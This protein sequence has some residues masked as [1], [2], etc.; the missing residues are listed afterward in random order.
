MHRALPVVLDIFQGGAPVRLLVV[1]LDAFRYNRIN[2]SKWYVE[3]K[4]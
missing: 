1:I 3:E 4:G 2:N